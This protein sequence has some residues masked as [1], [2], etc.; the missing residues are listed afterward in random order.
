M[1]EIYKNSGFKPRS[2]LGWLWLSFASFA[3]ISTLF[4]AIFS[5]ATEPVSL[6]AFFY[7]ISYALFS[8]LLFV[9]YKI[10]H[11]KQESIASYT[12]ALIIAILMGICMFLT[13]NI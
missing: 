12:L 3:M 5:V 6:S 8:I 7:S 2:V 9:L 11:L 13:N 10:F 4:V 1:T